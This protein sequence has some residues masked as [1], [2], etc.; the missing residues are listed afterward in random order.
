MALEAAYQLHYYLCFKTHFLK[1]LLT[2]PRLIDTVINDVCERQ[3]YHL[4]ESKLGEDHLRL[5]VSLQ[6]THSVSQ[7]VKMLKG[8][9]QHQMRQQL[10]I[11]NL[12][13]TGYFARTS[14]VVDLQRTRNYVDSQIRH[15]G[16]KG[17]WTKPLKY[18]N[19]QFHSP[20]FEFG[21]CVSILNYHLVFVTQERIPVFDEVVAPALFAC[22]TEVGQQHQFAI[23]RVGLLADHMH[24]L[25][26]GV[27]TM[28]PE[29]YAKVI[30]NE[31]REWMEQKYFGVLKQTG[32]WDLWQSSFYAGSVGQYT[33]AQVD[34]FLR[35]G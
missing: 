2:A 26:E 22:L 6:P 11:R 15:H 25:I 14:G 29:D 19:P 23:E 12:W 24:M 35:G 9:L 17:E 7:T 30:M 20:A 31:T 4:L 16:F 13:A 27:P 32:A 3:Q 33:T 1:P 18:C 8:N 28:S 5:L 34:K 21:H 10:N